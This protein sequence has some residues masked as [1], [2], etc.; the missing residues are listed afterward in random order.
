[1]RTTGLILAFC[2]LLSAPVL[3]Q[4]PAQQPAATPTRGM[5]VFGNLERDLDRAVVAGHGAEA[6]KLLAS[7]F[8]QRDAAAPAQPLPRAEWLASRRAGEPLPV[9]SQMTV[10]DFGS[11]AIVSFI[12]SVELPPPSMSRDNFLVDV[13][14]NE[15]GQWQLQVRYQAPASPQPAEPKPTGKE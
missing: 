7:D 14:R 13:W 15:G 12:S 6:G 2:G 3:A 9:I 11:L 5:V 4:L 1:M 8:E 10:H